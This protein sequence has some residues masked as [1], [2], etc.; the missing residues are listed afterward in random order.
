MISLRL[1]VT[2]LGVLTWGVACAPGPEQ[3]PQAVVRAFFA[4]RDAR[5]EQAV[6]ALLADD[7]VLRLTATELHGTDNVVQKLLDSHFTWETR[8]VRAFGET[9]T[10]MER[11]TED[12]PRMAGVPPWVVDTEMQAVV[13][14]GQIQSLSPTSQPLPRPNRRAGAAMQVT[15]ATMVPLAVL[16]LSLGALGTVAAVLRQRWSGAHRG[17]PPVRPRGRLLAQLR[18]PH[19]PRPEPPR[20]P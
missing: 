19:P 12:T 17:A 16:A 1:A 2:I 20:V 15:P 8:D 10:W 18:P 9:V 4:A 13:L 3:Q 6:R 14:D 5:D 11:M 7:V